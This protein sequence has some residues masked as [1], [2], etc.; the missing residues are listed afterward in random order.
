MEDSKKQNILIW[1]ILA[2]NLITLAVMMTVAAKGWDVLGNKIDQQA[3]DNNK[4]QEDSAFSQRQPMA[5]GQQAGTS[6][7]QQA[8]I[9]NNTT[10]G[11]PNNG[12]CGDGVCDSFEKTDSKICPLDCNK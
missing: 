8:P 9:G 7:Q 1:S 6:T 12:K 11:G 2:I 5:P 10:G 4:K 3:L